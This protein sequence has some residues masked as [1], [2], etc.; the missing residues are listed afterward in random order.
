MAN[1]FDNETSVNAFATDPAATADDELF[2]MP[3]IPEGTIVGYRVEPGMYPAVVTEAVWGETKKGDK[4]IVVSFD[5]DV[6]GPVVL[7]VRKT[8]R[9]KGMT[10]GGLAYF[11]RN[12]AGMGFKGGKV[13]LDTFVGNP[14][15]VRLEDYDSG[16]GVKSSVADIHP[17]PVDAAKVDD[18]DIKF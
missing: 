1:E 4:A 14:C 5:V 3:D 11:Q 13:K 17:R 7:S 16:T 12:M 10:P 2:E 18:D 15:M 9:V 8:M 6:G